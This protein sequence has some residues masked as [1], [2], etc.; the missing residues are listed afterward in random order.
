MKRVVLICS[1]LAGAGLAAPAACFAVSDNFASGFYTRGVDAAAYIDQGG[2]VIDPFYVPVQRLFLL[3]RVSLAVSHEDNVFLDP[4]EETRGTSVDLAPGLLAIWGR[5]GDNHVYADYGLNIPIYESVNELN[6]D[7]SHMLRLGSV[8]STGKSS[9]QGELGYRILEEDVD[10]TVGARVT[11][12][13]LFG[14]LNAEHRISGKSSVG[15]VGRVEVHLFDDDQ[16]GDYNRYYGGGRLYHRITPKSHG[17]VQAGL[18]RDDPQ[19]EAFDANGA[20]FYDLSL[21]VRGKQSP[22]FNSSG[23][24]GYMWRTYDEESRENYGNW[25]ASLRAESNPF[26]LT[27]FTGE[28]YADIRPSIDANGIDTLDQ[29]VVL[30]AARRMF[31]ERLR[32]NVSVTVGQ[33]D[34]SGQSQ[35]GT[36]AEGQDPLV[37]GGRSDTYWGFSLGVDWWTKSQFSIGLAYSYM[38]REGSQSGDQAAQEATSYEAGRFTLRASWNY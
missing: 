7:P 37:Y 4:V 20:D 26:G 6:P 24:V 28:L 15:G 13:D 35:A 9:V 38:N 23:R 19:D 11:K 33:I 1:W 10:A 27:L 3:P 16:Y 2:A 29:G 36:G 32:G 34:Y 18:G 8:Y 31:I 5:P 22:K 14:N 21:G 17:F 30:T 25:I 12:Q